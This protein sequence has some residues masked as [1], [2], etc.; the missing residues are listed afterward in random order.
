[1]TKKSP[2]A[3]GDVASI[4]ESQKLNDRAHSLMCFMQSEKWDDVDCL[5]TLVAVLCLYSKVTNIPPL[6]ITKM[7]T[8]FSKAISFPKED[9]Q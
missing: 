1:M 5:S 8:E 9:G 6:A 7:M 3:H 2:W 4:E